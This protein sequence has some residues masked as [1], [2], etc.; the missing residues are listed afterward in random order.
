[1]G[2]RSLGA[3]LVTMAL[4]CVA[5]VLALW[6]ERRKRRLRRERDAARRTG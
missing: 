3:F 1:M 4:F 2:H 5:F 6:W